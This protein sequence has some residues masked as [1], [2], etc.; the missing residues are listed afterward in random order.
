MQKSPFH[1]DVYIDGGSRGNPGPAGAGIIIETSSK[2]YNFSIP[3]GHQTNNF[4]EYEALLFAL[5]Q[6]I[7]LNLKDITIYSD[8]ELLV[9]QMKGIYKVK[10]SNLKSS[11]EKAKSLCQ[12]LNN[13]EFIYIP[14]EKN[15][16]ADKLANLAM[17]K[18]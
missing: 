5:K 9:M 8:S 7:K 16:E 3:L 17:D 12:K 13:I 15:K 14:R 4:A 18:V 1:A 10:S 6:A 11:F 2:N